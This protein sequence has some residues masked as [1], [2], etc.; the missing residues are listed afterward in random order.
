MRMETKLP[1]SKLLHS[2]VIFNYISIIL[3]LLFF[4]YLFKKTK[5]D[6]EILKEKKK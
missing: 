4:F 2:A 5:L 3:N 1:E 6:I